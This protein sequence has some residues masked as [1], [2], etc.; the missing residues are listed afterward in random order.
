[1]V[2]EDTRAEGPLGWLGGKGDP[3]FSVIAVK[4]AP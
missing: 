4:G 1:V 3:F 2:A